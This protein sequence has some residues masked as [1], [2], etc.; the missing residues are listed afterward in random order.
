MNNSVTIKTKE[1]CF[2]AAPELYGLFFED[3]NRAADGGLYPEML[4]NRAFEDSIIPEGCTSDPEHLIYINEGGWPGVFNHGEGMDE[5]AAVVPE[6]RIPAW[7]EDNADMELLF[8]DTLNEQRK[9]ALKVRFHAG[10]SIYNIGFSGIHAEKDERVHFYAFLKAQSSC[11]LHLSLRDWKDCTYGTTMI[12]VKA[13]ADYIRYDAELVSE[14][15]RSDFSLYLSCDQ[16]NEM[17]FGFTSLMPEYSFKGH[18]LREDLALTLKNTHSKFIRFP[19]GC[20]VE[21]INEKNTMAF[22]KTIGPVWERPSSQLMWH[23]RTTNGLGFHE[24][25]Q[26]CEDLDME[27]LYVCN[28][29]MSCQARRMGG[30]P[31]ETVKEYLDEALHA[32]EYALGGKDTFYGG[33]RAAMGHPEPFRLKYLEI[34]NEN[35]GPEYAPRY[36]IFQK[37]ISEAFPEVILIS[38]GHTEREGLDTAFVDEHYYNAPEFFLENTDMFE[39]YPRKGPKIFLGEYAVN[40]GRT[41]A[42]L[43]CALAEAAF[44]TGVERNQDVVRL[45]AYAPLMQNADYTAW[46]PNLIV[47]NNHTVYGIPSYHAISLFAKYRGTQVVPAALTGVSDPPAYRGIPGIQSEKEDLYFKNVRINGDEM[48]DLR[49]LYGDLV[50]D[51]D[52][53][54]YTMAFGTGRHH[55]AGKNQVWNQ[56][57]EEFIYSGDFREKPIL[58]TLFE[59]GEMES[60]RFEFDARFGKDNP[61]TFSVFNSCPASDSGC[62]EPKDTDW[63]RRVIRNQLWHIE[64][65]MSSLRV[66]RIFEK[67]LAETEKKTLKIDY[68]QY[69]HY[70][71]EADRFGY[72]CLIN[73]VVVDEKVQPLHSVLHI[74][75]ETTEQEI[76]MKTVNVSSEPQQLTVKLDT[77]ITRTICREWISGIPETQNSFQDPEA[78]SPSLK[79]LDAELTELPD[80]VEFTITVPAYSVSVYVMKKL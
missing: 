4:R 72:R 25:L 36:E 74:S 43:E 12:E 24:Y 64:D 38:N 68:T 33:I 75:C 51:E 56:A 39:D 76:F 7:Y 61:V 62:N 46:K 26:L 41:I 42:S 45:T 23:Y 21:G 78:V 80:G 60:L 19:G 44:L 63:N 48:K 73:D 66:P 13:S 29:G 69:N 31:E 2:S 67:P 28:C 14:A 10:G 34:G 3:I 79:T 53:Q 71:I 77:R 55:Y 70:C 65:G 5:W 54:A 15:D 8:S 47:F 27:A 11:H 30:Y 32:L 37:T 57:F 59:T 1:P 18:G 22:S 58:W 40:G 17:I 50:W 6:T 20:V 16:E 49:A 35:F 9:A 52:E